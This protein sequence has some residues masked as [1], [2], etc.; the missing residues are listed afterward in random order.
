MWRARWRRQPAQGCCHVWIAP[1]LQAQSLMDVDP[2]GCGHVSGLL[3]RPVRTSRRSATRRPCHSRSATPRLF[4][5]LV[6][7]RNAFR[8][9]NGCAPTNGSKRF[10]ADFI[11]AGSSTSLARVFGTTGASSRR[12]WLDYGRSPGGP[13]CPSLLSQ[14]ARAQ[15]VCDDNLGLPQRFIAFL[16]N[17]QGSDLISPRIFT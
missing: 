4:L 7:S 5:M 11:C 17:F 3:A 8:D 14:R 15:L 16:R 6:W 10:S 2:M 1:V 13:R 12:G 9:R